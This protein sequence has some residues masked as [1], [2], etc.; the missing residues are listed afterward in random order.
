MSSRPKTSRAWIF[1]ESWNASKTTLDLQVWAH[2]FLK[3][4]GS[5]TV[6]PYWQAATA[7]DSKTPCVCASLPILPMLWR[8]WISSCS[9]NCPLPSGT[10]AFRSDCQ[11]TVISLRLGGWG[12]NFDSIELQWTLQP[13]LDQRAVKDSSPRTQEFKFVFGDQISPRSGNLKAEIPNLPVSS[14]AAK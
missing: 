7:A 10:A 12:M 13:D 3:Q 14:A 6:P 5:S 11:M 1:F 9:R 2:F 4:A 8:Y